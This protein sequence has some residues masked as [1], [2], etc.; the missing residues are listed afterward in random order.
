MGIS[1]L[2]LGHEYTSITTSIA[3][4]SQAYAMHFVCV[5]LK[6]RAHLYA[7]RQRMKVNLCLAANSA[8]HLKHYNF[9]N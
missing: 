1:S 5:L 4:T 9:D 7:N 6:R 2:T 8:Y 3:L